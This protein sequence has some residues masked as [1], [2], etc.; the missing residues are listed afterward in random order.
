LGAGAQARWPAVPLYLAGFSFGGM[1]S[2]RATALRSAAALITVAPAVRYL[3]TQQP[4]HPACPWLVIQGLKD[5]VVDPDEVIAWTRSFDPRPI[6]QSIA[7]VG[8]YFHGSLNQITAAMD[9]FFKTLDLPESD[10]IDR[11]PHAKGVV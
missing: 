2:L 6:L 1:V 10:A 4:V 9:S 3:R 5:E 8:H 7:D 11:R